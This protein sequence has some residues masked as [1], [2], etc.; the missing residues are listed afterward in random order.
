MLVK[1]DLL[2]SVLVARGWTSEFQKKRR[3][4]NKGKPPAT[5]HG[6]SGLNYG[7]RNDLKDHLTDRAVCL[8]QID[9]GP[10]LAFPF[11]VRPR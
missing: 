7:L 9:P 10:G 5:G 4:I 2:L 6:K 11:T 8:G 1:G 3:D